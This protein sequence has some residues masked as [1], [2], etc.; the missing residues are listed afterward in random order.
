MRF[1]FVSGFGCSF[2]HIRDFPEDTLTLIRII[3]SYSR[4]QART[5][6]LFK[7]RGTDP[8]QRSLDSLNLADDIN[9]VRPIIY[10]PFDSSDMSLNVFQA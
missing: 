7:D 6:V 1:S 9:T 10:H 5:K 4:D 3:T 8:V 2:E